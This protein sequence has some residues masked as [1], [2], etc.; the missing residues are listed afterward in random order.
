MEER[1]LGRTRRRV[2]ILGL[3][4]AGFLMDQHRTITDR[5][6]VAT[7]RYAHS[8]G[9]RFFDTSPLYGGG[10]SERRLGL[11]L[12]A[13]PAYIATKCGLYLEG[14]RAMPNDSWDRTIASVERSQELLQRD[15]LDL[16][17]IHELT[18]ERWDAVFAARGTLAALR[19]LQDRGVVACVG[20]TG[21]DPTPLE[22]AIR[23]GE[24]DT[25]QVW[26]SWNLLDRSAHKVIDAAA[27]RGV[28]IIVGGPFASGILA[29]RTGRAGELHYRKATRPERVA[30]VR[31][32]AAARRAGS[33]LP[34]VAL[35]FAAA[36]PV[37]VVLTGVRTRGQ[38]D[39]NL[40]D[41][42]DPLALAALPAVSE[43]LR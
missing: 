11:A 27:Q 39:Q 30:A 8:R 7:V 37:S 40:T 43:E 2:P 16:V 17:Q 9:I 21:S 29:K 25:V 19:H 34:A 15:R 42:Q 24:F 26:K 10:T 5:T 1:E 35:A 38:I 22:R 31:A 41:L 6:A 14:S 4:G 13:R 23:T 20:V 32:A 3:G 18:T 33:S 12:R 28:G 36:P